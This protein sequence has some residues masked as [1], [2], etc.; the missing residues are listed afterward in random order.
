[1]LDS[2]WKGINALMGLFFGLAALAQ[3]ND[4]DPEFFMVGLVSWLCASLTPF[5]PVY[6]FV[7]Y[8]AF[9]QCCGPCPNPLIL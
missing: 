1:M 8:H 3:Y 5:Q 2:I 4:P 6:S 7:S 9:K